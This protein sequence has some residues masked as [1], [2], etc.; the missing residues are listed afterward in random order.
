MK[1]VSGELPV[2]EARWAFEIKWD[3]VRVLAHLDHGRI[4][5]RSSRGNDITMRYPELHGL[6]A[7]LGQHSVVLDGEVVA[8]DAEGR[9][10][11]GML[12]S[13]MHLA[14]AR[15]VAE[16]A[17]HVPIAY[18]LFDLVRLDGHDVGQLPYVERRH[19]L[20]DLIDPAQGWQIPAHRIGDGA[21]LLEAVKRQGLEGVMAKRPDSPY[22]PGKRSPAWRKIKARLRQELVV[23]GWQPGDGNRSG[24]LG[25]LLV[26]VYEAGRLRFSG[27]VGTGFDDAELKRLGGL[28]EGVASDACPFDPPPPR[29]IARAAR[30]VRPE[31][32]AEVEFGEWTAEGI[33][34]H[35]AYLG[36]R[37]D[38]APTDV[39]REGGG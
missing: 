19:I 28:L 15:Q 31:L 35:A 24:R 20:T 37:D 18:V 21:A 25:S 27:K 26:G 8:F 11:F 39:V 23:G 34:R 6:A 38:K 33:L 29:P 13:R 22:V 30:W 7:V 2:D 32:V 9:P 36:L 17:A 12:Q 1:A 4:K 3:G 5:L 14:S 10:S 16:R